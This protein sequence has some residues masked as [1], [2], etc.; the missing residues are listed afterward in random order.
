MIEFMT[1]DIENIKLKIRT[2][3]FFSILNS[4]LDFHLPVLEP[5]GGGDDDD[6][7]QSRASCARFSPSNRSITY[8]N[9]V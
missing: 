8:T 4:P 9:N 3:C 2:Y 1:Q 7:D 6:N 5:E